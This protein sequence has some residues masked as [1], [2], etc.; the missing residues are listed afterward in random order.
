M[1]LEDEHP[2]RP[3]S[4]RSRPSRARDE[5]AAEREKQRPKTAVLPTRRPPLPRFLAV[6]VLSGTHEE[7][8]A[9]FHKVYSAATS[10]GHPVLPK[11]EK[12]YYLR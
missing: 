11:P 4:E 12:Q 6:W 3:R 2:L 10:E 7:M 8:Q 1:T 5:D 9:V